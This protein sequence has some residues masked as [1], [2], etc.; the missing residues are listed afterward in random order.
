MIPVQNESSGY[1]FMCDKYS[2]EEAFFYGQFTDKKDDVS[3]DQKPPETPT[4]R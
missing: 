1:L 3:R 2:K 4:D